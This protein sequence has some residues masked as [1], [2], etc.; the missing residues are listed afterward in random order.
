MIVMLQE[1]V[2][3]FVAEYM[4]VEDKG[5]K[6]PKNQQETKGYSSWFY[7]RRTSA[8]KKISANLSTSDVSSPESEKLSDVK[9]VHMW[10][11]MIH[12]KV[13]AHLE[14]KFSTLKQ[15]PYSCSYLNHMGYNV[16]AREALCHVGTE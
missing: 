7:W 11:I 5:Q 4:P 8:P 9:E 12:W 6:K 3:A 10:L 16:E 14:K 15:M 2:D 1:V 13:R